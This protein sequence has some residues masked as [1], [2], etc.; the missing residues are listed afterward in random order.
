GEL[1]VADGNHRSLAAQI[2][3]LPRFL[4]VVT[5]PESVAIQPY[6]RLITELPISVAA[7]LDGLRTAGAEVRPG[8][9]GI[10][11]QGTIIVYGRDEAPR[12]PRPAAS[13][14]FDADSIVEGMDHAGVERLL[15]REVLGLDPGDKR[16][17]YVGGD[18]PPAWLRSE[19]D[20]GRAEA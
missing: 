4:A 20:S 1:V 13:A 10:P 16:I 15:M 3:R 5:T 12:G 2:G 9:V 8:E 18:Y 17:V 6:H 7:V 14:P 11:G 19:V